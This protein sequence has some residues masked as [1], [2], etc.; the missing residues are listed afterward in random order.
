MPRSDER[1]DDETAERVL[2]FT[3]QLLRNLFEVPEELRLIT[4]GPGR[5]T[6]TQQ[7]S[8]PRWWVCVIP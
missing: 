5:L 3:T 4:G 1:V 8:P 7:N 2:E 6:G